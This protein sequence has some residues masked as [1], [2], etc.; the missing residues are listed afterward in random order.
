[1]KKLFISMAF[2]GISEKEVM[3]HRKE[4]LDHLRENNFPLDEYELIDNYHH[5]DAPENASR[6]W[7]L[8]RSIQQMSQADIIYFTQDD[9]RGVIIE[10]IIAALYGLPVLNIN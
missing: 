1:M 8:G 6:L 5:N 9:A 7:H 3:Q 4:I 10:K 2:N